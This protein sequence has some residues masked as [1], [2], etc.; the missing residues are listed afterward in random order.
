[1]KLLLDENLPRQLKRELEGHTVFTA[2]EMGWNGKEN[3]EL[4]ALLLENNFQALLTGDKNIPRQQNFKTYTIPVIVLNTRF[5]T[6]PD[7]KPLMPI[8]QDLLKTNLPSG[9]TVVSL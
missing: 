8:V 9:P 3:G 1:M 2:A 7:L 4:L 5:I 6:Y